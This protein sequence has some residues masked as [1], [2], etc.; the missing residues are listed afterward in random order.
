MTPIS[1]WDSSSVEEDYHNPE[2]GDVAVDVAIIGGGYTGLS[3]ALHCAQ[4]GLSANVLEAKR[5]GYGG[6]GRNVGLVNA[7]VWHP[8]DKVRKALGA[9]YGPR[10]VARFGAAPQ[11]VFDLIERHQIR[12][13]MTRSGT[14]HA[15]HAPSGLSDLAA[16][17]AEWQR[18]GAPVRLLDREEMAQM[19]GTHKFHGGLLDQRAGT[20]NPMGYCRGLARAARGAGARITTGVSATALHKQGGGWHVET[21]RGV[22]RARTVVLATNAYTDALW[23]GLQRSFTMVNYFQLATEPLGARVHHILPDRQGL[24][25]TG[26][27]LFSLRRDCADRLIIGSMGKVLGAAKTGISQ[28][29][30]R[31]TL[32]RLF[33]DLGTVTFGQAWHGQIA[34]TPDHL[35]RVSILDEGLYAAIGYNGRGITTG[36]IFGEAIAEL[37]TG[38]DP[39]DLPLPLSQPQTVRS[40][41]LLAR[42]Y[43][44]A[45]SAK[46]LMKSL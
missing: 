10:F 17:H 31:K 19:T 15:A 42:A 8:P 21:D 2:L 4:K 12:C 18:L 36:T 25:D 13:E 30:A 20:V 35:P 6:S 16:R 14:I 1:L 39:T 7:G 33:P 46:Q 45:F 22:V 41:P 34:M 5:I 11:K 3:T 26:R 40:G 27:I 43:Q 9:V 24:W 32:A 38:A 44:F 37:L 29:W 28:R 23:P